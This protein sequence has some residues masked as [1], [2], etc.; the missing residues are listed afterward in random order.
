MPNSSKRVQ[1]GPNGA[2]GA[3]RVQT[4][5]NGSYSAKQGQTGPNGVKLGHLWATQATWCQTGANGAKQGRTILGMF[6]DHPW[7][8]Q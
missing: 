5:P 7:V 1:T 4:G 8:G 3:K 6:G 2:N